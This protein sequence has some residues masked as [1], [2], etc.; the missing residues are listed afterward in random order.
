M[1]NV[2]RMGKIGVYGSKTRMLQRKLSYEAVGLTF[3]E[4]RFFLF[5]GD[6]DDSTLSPTAFKDKVFYEIINR[7]YSKDYIAIP[8]AFDPRT[9]MKTD[10][11]RFGLVNP[12]TAEVEYVV[13]IDDCALLGREPVIGDVFELPFFEDTVGYSVWEIVDVDDKRSYEEYI[14]TLTAVPVTKSRATRDLTINSDNESVFSTLMD[15][16]DID[17]A[18]YVPTTDVSANQTTPPKSTDISYIQ[19]TQFDFL[20][21]PTKHF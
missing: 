21:D 20:N 5:Q 14:Y 10:F 2:A 15:E 18:S 13:H 4:A 3:K 17:Y 19:G 16:A 9:H 6:K 11:S 12:M 7:S 1:A 8:V